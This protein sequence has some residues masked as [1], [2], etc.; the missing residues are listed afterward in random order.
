MAY[1]LFPMWCRSPTITL[2]PAPIDLAVE[3]RWTPEWPCP[4]AA[5]LGAQR[6]GAGDP[7][8][9]ID[10]DG[11]HWRGFRT[12]EGTASL[13]VSSSRAEGAIDLMA[14]GSGADWIIDSAPALLGAEDDPSGFVAHHA[15][16]A[17][18]QRRHSHWRLGRSGMVLDALV[19]AIIEQKVTGKEAFSSYRRLVQTY[20]EPAPG[21]AAGTLGLWVAP[22]PRTITMIASWEWLQISVDAGRSR[23]LV[24]AARVADSLERAAARGSA[25]LDRALL[26]LPGIG[27]WTSA[28]V[29]QRS[30]GDADAVSFGDYHVANDIGWALTGEPVDDDGLAELLEPYRPHRYRVQA[31]LGLSGAHR[32][33]RG[34]RMAPRTH[35]PVGRFA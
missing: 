4:V 8:Y 15:P 27:R 5:V 26:S 11:A 28:E 13:R 21:P 35:L 19:P 6:H 16:V 22:S 14:W 2:M 7:T 9:R 32:P 18:A 12:P 33:R 30:L 3:R 23:A 29:R 24:A 25:E 20:G 31:L 10:A 1:T 17:D 34:P